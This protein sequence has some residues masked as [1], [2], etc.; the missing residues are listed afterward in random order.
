[1]EIESLYIDKY[2]NIHQQTFDFTDVA[3]PIILIGLNGFGKGNL[4]E[5]ISLIFKS[6]VTGTTSNIRYQITFSMQGKSFAV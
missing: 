5:A 3:K 4:L 2:K 1:M 6:A